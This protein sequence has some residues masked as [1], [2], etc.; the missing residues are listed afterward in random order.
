MDAWERAT[1]DRPRVDPMDRRMHEDRLAG[2]SQRRH[3]LAWTDLPAGAFVVVDARAALVLPDRLVP[4]Q[5]LEHGYGQPIPRPGAGTAEVL[6][7]AST[8]DVL[9]HGYEPI[10]HP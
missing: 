10:I 4:W 5:P 3:Q 8:V 6:T 2:R 9:R 1:G 7:P